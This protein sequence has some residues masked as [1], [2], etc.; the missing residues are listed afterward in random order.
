MLMKGYGEQ[1]VKEENIISL[2][3]DDCLPTYLHDFDLFSCIAYII[4][5]MNERE[6]NIY[7]LVSLEKFESC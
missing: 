2:Y 5:E 6:M 1:L 7:L 4:T 3:L